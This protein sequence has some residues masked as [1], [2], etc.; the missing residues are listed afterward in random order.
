MALIPEYQTFID[1]LAA[2]GGPP[3]SEMSV[4][5]AREMFRVGYPARPD[6]EVGL[7]ENK[8]I[9]VG[10]R[11]IPIRAYTPQ[12]EGP[13]PATM[14]FH[15]GGWVIGD[16]DTAD[17]QSRYICR[18]TPCVVVSVDY[19]LAPEYPFPAAPEDCYE[20]TRWVFQN[21]DKLNVD[22][23]RIAV[24]GDSAGGNLTA[25]VA[26]MARDRG[27]PPLVFQWMIYPVT[28]GSTFDTQSYADNAE[29]YMLT[30]ASMHWFW[31]FYAS[32]TDRSHAHAS[33]LCSSNLSNLPPAYV[34]VAQYDPLRD[35]GIQYAEALSKA[36][37]ATELSNY[38]GFIHGFIQHT[39]SVPPTKVALEDGCAAL[40]KAFQG[41]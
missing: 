34:Q 33:P 14:M 13:F 36:G 10:S 9:Q 32:K 15:G 4:S 39:D 29:G 41:E 24:T 26:Q 25:V 1:Q 2:L 5:A 27:D 18:D 6:I 8:T 31:D 40:R 38:R 19:R 23:N 3:L 17:G 22:P 35:E 28:N 7:V 11:E 37:V 30:A 21:S 12:G 16:L 20:A